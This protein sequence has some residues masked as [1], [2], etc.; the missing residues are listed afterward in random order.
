MFCI[1]QLTAFN[2]FAAREGMS[3]NVIHLQWQLLYLTLTKRMSGNN[4]FR[5][6]KLAIV[7]L[8]VHY[9]RFNT[10]RPVCSWKLMHRGPVGP[11]CI[12]CNEHKGR[13]C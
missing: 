1:L 2:R 12:N 11:E 7:T 9:V 3:T 13:M 8:S 10:W 6:P 4:Y 5:I